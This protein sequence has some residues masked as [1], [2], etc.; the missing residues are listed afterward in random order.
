MKVIEFFGMPKAGKT[1]AIEVAESYLK[2]DGKKVRT[3]YEGARISPLDKKDRFM[4]NS[5]S[6]HN[7]INRILEARL[8]NYDFILVDRGVLDH[9]AFWK[10]ISLICQDHKYNEIHDYFSNFIGL[11]DLKI[12]FMLSPQ[13][14]IE[15]ERK[16]N[17]FLGRVFA[18]DFLK[19]LYGAYRSTAS[20]FQDNKLVEI[21]G[22][23]NIKTNLEK[24]MGIFKE[25]KEN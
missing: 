14:A 11:E 17:P 10:A 22:G 5:W 13:E 23:N 19:S 6:F 12:L 20:E 1:T 4:Y 18:G 3:V 25:L 8:D 2:N 16:N 24:L 7:T 21:N 9:I 15:R